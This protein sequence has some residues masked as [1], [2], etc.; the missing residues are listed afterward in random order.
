MNRLNRALRAYLIWRAEGHR[1]FQRLGWGGRILVLLAAALAG[2]A[3][4]LAAARLLLYENPILQGAVLGAVLVMVMS[5]AGLLLARR[6]SPPPGIVNPD[7][8]RGPES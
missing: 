7:P 5:P 1:A 8:D 4:A 3:A 2:G 6:L